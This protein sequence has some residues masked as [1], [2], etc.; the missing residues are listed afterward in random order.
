[1][2]STSPCSFV[3]LQCAAIQELKDD[4][5]SARVTYLGNGDTGIST[6]G[7]NSYPHELGTATKVD[8]FDV[9][10]GEGHLHGHWD[11]TALRRH[12]KARIS[13]SHNVIIYTDGRAGRCRSRTVS[14]Y[15]SANSERQALRCTVKGTHR[16]L[17]ISV[18]TNAVVT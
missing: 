2:G 1:M 9:H 6:F 18:C 13:Y 5:T 11:E 14:P 8:I 17:F 16:S 15:S 7:D 10:N 12:V 3:H 4:A